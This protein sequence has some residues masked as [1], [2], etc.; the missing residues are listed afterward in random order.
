MKQVDKRSRRSSQSRRVLSNEGLTA[1]VGGL[2]FKKTG[3]DKEDPQSKNPGGTVG[4]Q[5]EQKPQPLYPY[6]PYFP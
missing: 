1:V 6:Y 2:G 5:G 3:E 4:P